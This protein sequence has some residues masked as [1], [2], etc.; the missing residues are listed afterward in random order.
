MKLCELL[1][2]VN[3]LKLEKY[4][5]VIIPRVTPRGIVVE[6]TPLEKAMVHPDGDMKLSQLCESLKETAMLSNCY[7]T[8]ATSNDWHLHIASKGGKKVVMFK[9]ELYAG[10]ED[11]VEKT[12]AE[13]HSVS[14]NR[15]DFC[16]NMRS[17]NLI[18][19]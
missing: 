7:I 14:V 15:I 11:I 12:S 5:R 10:W 16:F 9:G 18:F 6:D 1:D 17:F 2:E 13:L 8:V 3:K 4:R 19:G